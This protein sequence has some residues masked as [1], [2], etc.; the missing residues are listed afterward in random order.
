M[1]AMLRDIYNIV[2]ANTQNE[3]SKEEKNFTDVIY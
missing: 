2:I 1:A 3:G